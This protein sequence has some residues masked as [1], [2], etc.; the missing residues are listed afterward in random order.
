MKIPENIVL[1]KKDKC[2]KEDKTE[3]FP[4]ENKNPGTC[5]GPRN[6][7]EFRSFG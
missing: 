1:L 3:K 4:A 5:G 2:A 7:I 6:M